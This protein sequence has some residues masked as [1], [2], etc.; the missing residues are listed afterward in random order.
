MINDGVYRSGF[1]K[2]QSA[3]EKAVKEVFKGLDRVEEILSKKHYLTGNQLT[4]A[5]VRLYTSLIRFDCAYYFI[6]KCNIKRIVDYPN[7]QKYLKEL[8]QLESFKSTTNFDHIKKQYHSN[9]ELNPTKIIPLGPI[10][11][12][13]TQ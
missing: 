1:A 13:N 6:F 7:I 3:Y 11:D 12:L 10:L 4:E 5:D 2:S 8:Y 9:E